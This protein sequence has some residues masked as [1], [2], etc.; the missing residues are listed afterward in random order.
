MSDG[1]GCNDLKL[2]LLKYLAIVVWDRY[3]SLH[4]TN[5]WYTVSNIHN[6]FNLIWK[7]Y[8]NINYDIFYLD[9]TLII[10]TVSGHRSNCVAYASDLQTSLKYTCPNMLFICSSDTCG[11]P[12]KIHRIGQL[13]PNLHKCTQGCERQI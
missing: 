8:F 6:I 3:N 9:Y 5:N 10:F 7:C 1:K 4:P 12:Y 13:L 11:T 2:R